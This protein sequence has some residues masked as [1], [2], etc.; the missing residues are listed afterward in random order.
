MG[1]GIGTW[2]GAYSNKLMYNT[3]FI[4]LQNIWTGFWELYEAFILMEYWMLQVFLIHVKY[5]ESHVWRRNHL[6]D[7]EKYI[8][9][10]ETQIWPKLI[11]CLLGKNML[12][13]QTSYMQLLHCKIN[14]TYHLLRSAVGIAHVLQSGLVMGYTISYFPLIVLGYHLDPS[15]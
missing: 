4:S 9:V 10:T 6:E 12:Y 3:T 1:R 2:R 13:F 7:S 14:F 11:Q 8:L 5:R 15:R